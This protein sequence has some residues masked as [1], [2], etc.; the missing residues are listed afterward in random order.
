LRHACSPRCCSSTNFSKNCDAQLARVAAVNK[1]AK[2]LVDRRQ[3]IEDKF[4]RQVQLVV[5][6]FDALLQRA[7]PKKGTSPLL[8]AS[9]QGCSA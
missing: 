8:L 7:L 4:E 1:E 2:V 3:A 5:Q 9:Q 6:S